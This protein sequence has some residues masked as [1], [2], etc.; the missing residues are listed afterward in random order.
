MRQTDV[1]QVPLG[2]RQ[3]G[4]V[5]AVL[6]I[7]AHFGRAERDRSF[8][9]AVQVSTGEVQ[10][11]PVLALP[12]LWNRQEHQRREVPILRR[13]N[14]CEE[15]VCSGQHGTFHQRRPELGEL[16]RDAAV[17]DDLAEAE[18]CAH[19]RFLSW[20]C[21]ARNSRKSTTRTGWPSRCLPARLASG[22]LSTDMQRWRRADRDRFTAPR[23]DRVVSG[24]HRSA[25]LRRELGLADAVLVGLGAMLGAGVFAA[26]GPAATAA[27]AGLLIG[28]PVA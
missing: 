15:L 6:V 17:N 14:R 1:E 10:M 3:R 12:W 19:Q 27:G 2:I 23:D 22:T 9:G 18:R 4:P 28:L 5:R 20:G 26:W 21:G 13:R 16:I 25:A 11:Q 24:Q 8:D 7:F